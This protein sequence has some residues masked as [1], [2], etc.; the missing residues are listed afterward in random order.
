MGDS[1]KYPYLPTDGFHILTPALRT[2]LVYTTKNR[3]LFQFCEIIET[4][5]ELRFG[6]D[7]KF[8]DIFQLEEY[9]FVERFYEKRK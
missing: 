7:F 8:L 9:V 6:T 2:L 4:Q 1:R 5:I 3:A